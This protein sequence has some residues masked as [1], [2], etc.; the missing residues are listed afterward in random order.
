MTQMPV[1]TG[2]SL[3]RDGTTPRLSFSVAASI[4]QRLRVREAQADGEWF[5]L[6]PNAAI[7]EHLKGVAGAVADRQ[8]DMIGRDMRAVTEHHTKNLSAA[9]PSL[10]DFEIFDLALETIFATESLDSLADTFHDHHQAECADVGLGDIKDLGRSTGSDQFGQHLATVMMRVL[11]L[12]V[13]LAV[14]KSASSS[15]AELNIRFRVWHGSAP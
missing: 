4:A 13:E 10:I 12:A 9:V 2:F 7:P 8:H 5:S 1:R 6:H 14:G 11:N 3:R 15:F